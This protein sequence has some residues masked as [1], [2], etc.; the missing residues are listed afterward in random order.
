M[1]DSKLKKAS[2]AVLGAIVFASDKFSTVAEMVEDRASAT[3]FPEAVKHFKALEVLREELAPVARAFPLD[4]PALK[5]AAQKEGAIVKTVHFV[6]H[7]QGVHNLAALTSVNKCDCKNPGNPPVC[8]YVQPE[9]K[10]A[11]LTELG[12]SQATA[13]QERAAQCGATLVVVSPLQ[14]A[15]QTAHLAF[16]KADPRPPFQALEDAR[17]QIGAHVCDCRRPIADA[18]AQFPYVCFDGLAEGE[19]PLW[20]TAREPKT[21]VAARAQNVVRW[22]RTRPE[23]NIAVVCHSSF[24]LTLFNIAL[25]CSPDPTLY[26]WFETGEM[27]SVAVVW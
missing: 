27:R 11:R 17:E 23:E 8:P 14:R 24:L 7:G 20:T 15:L 22:L 2:L 16:L 26:E 3:K 13:L 9:V 4:S 10:D 12:E 19:D 25:D 21:G 18:K 5:E 1:S 6:R